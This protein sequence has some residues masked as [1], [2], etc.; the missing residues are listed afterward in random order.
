MPAVLGIELQ[1]T[2]H[3]APPEL[4]AALDRAILHYSNCVGIYQ[5]L[6]IGVA[7]F[8]GVF[9]DGENAA[10]EWF[11]WRGGRLEHSDAAYGHVEAALRDVLVNLFPPCE[12]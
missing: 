1:L 7:E 5:L 9:G 4:L 2:R 3:E 10:Y 11:V 12:Y 8:C 6:A